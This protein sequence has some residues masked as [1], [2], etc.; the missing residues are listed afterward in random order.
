MNAPKLHLLLMKEVQSPAVGEEASDPNYG[1][2]CVLR[3]G[4]HSVV[5]SEM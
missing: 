2:E 4:T 5:N 1:Y 3:N